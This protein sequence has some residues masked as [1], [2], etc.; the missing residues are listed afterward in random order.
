MVSHTAGQWHYGN[1]LTSIA[2]PIPRIGNHRK[3][4]LGHHHPDPH[5]L[6]TDLL[7]PCGPVP[8]PYREPVHLK[9]HGDGMSL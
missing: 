9:L 5:R 3:Y 6:S 2:L 4:F 8:T 1:H 7:L